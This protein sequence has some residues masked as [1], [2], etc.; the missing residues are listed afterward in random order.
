MV[1][2][3]L[4]VDLFQP[5]TMPLPTQ[6]L[7]TTGCAIWL[8]R[9]PQNVPLASTARNKPTLLVTARAPTNYRKREN[10]TLERW[11]STTAKRGTLYFAR[12]TRLTA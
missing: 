2:M 7:N 5:S 8:D 11:T 10:V 12:T 3:E 6:K 1:Y 9:K 4:I